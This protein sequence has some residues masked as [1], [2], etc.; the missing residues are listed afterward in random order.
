M[1]MTKQT[2]ALTALIA[3]LGAVPAMA[4]TS[5]T[6]VFGQATHA[7]ETDG[8]KNVGNGL[9]AGVGYRFNDNFA[10]EGGYTGLRDRHNGMADQSANVRGVAILPV[11]PKVDVFGKLGYARTGDTLG[12]G[13]K[14][15]LTAGVGASYALDQNWSIRADYDRLKDRGDQKLN[16]YSAGV[17]YKF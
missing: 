15:G 16:T 11:T 12:S 5:G 1:S 9:G 4:D 2:I 17:Q 3:G 8:A 7:R 13:G 10:V 6:Y 14:D